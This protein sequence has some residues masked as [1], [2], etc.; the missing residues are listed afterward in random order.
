MNGIDLKVPTCT[1]AIMTICCVFRG[2]FMQSAYTDPISWQFS[3]LGE[4]LTV[5]A[6]H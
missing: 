4:G 3:T 2:Y 5:L 1:D 6:S